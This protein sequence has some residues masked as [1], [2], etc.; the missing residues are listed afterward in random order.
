MLLISLLLVLFSVHLVEATSIVKVTPVKDQ[1]T[2]S[3]EADFKVEVTNKEVLTQRYSLYSLQG[4]QGWT[5]EPSPLKDRI[6]EL[7]GG[8]TFTTHVKV[9]P[10]DSFTPG[11]YYITINIESDRGEKYSE[12]L[13]VYLGAEKPLDYLP[14]IK[15]TVDMDDKINPQEPVSIKLFLENKNPLDLS[16]LGVRIQS[17]IPEFVQEVSVDLPPLEKKTVEFAVIPTPFQQPKDYVLFFVFERKGQTIKVVE[18]RVQV[19]SMIPGFDVNATKDS[20]LLKKLI[21]LN[22]TNNGNVLNE[23]EIKYPLTWWQSLFVGEETSIKVLGEQ[24]YASWMISLQPGQSK[25]IVLVINY[26]LWLYLLFIILVFGGF[27]WYVQSPITL[28]KTA[29]TTKSGDDGTLSEVKVTLEV[30]NRS[31]KSLKNINIIDYVPTIAHIEKSLELGTLKPQEVQHNTKKG[32]MVKWILSEVEAK[33]QRLITYKVKA[34]LN[35]V[36]TFSLPRATVEFH[37]GKKQRK[38]YSNVFRLSS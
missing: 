34:K 23:Q 33:E 32:T 35:I 27:Y 31:N 3:E 5:V 6:F 17:D 24:R 37:R 21:G 13:K 9:R 7:N 29:T 26:R 12:P 22:I 4:G 15:V 18:Q 30:R 11:I 8:T 14:S 19:L 25:E 38:A 10:L 16:D 28:N 1:I 20:I 2:P 36:G